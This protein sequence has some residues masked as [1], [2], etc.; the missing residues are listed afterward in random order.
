MNHILALQ[1]E[2]SNLKFQLNQVNEELT[3]FMAHLHSP[4]FQ[5]TQADGS[6]KDWISTGDV[7][8]TI[9]EIRSLTLTN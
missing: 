9:K 6:R 3:R 7:L 5:G 1:A 4:K 2:V 8:N